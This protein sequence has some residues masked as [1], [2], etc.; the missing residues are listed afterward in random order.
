MKN[1]DLPPGASDKCPIQPWQPWD[2]REWS[3]V[4]NGGEV[5]PAQGEKLTMWTS[6]P[7]Y[8][9]DQVNTPSPT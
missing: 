7:R 4:Q 2:K 5:Y 3:V 6:K 8:H 1:D 9:D